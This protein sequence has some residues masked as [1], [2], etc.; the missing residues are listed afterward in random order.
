MS[1]TQPV[2]PIRYQE[3]I[4]KDFSNLSCNFSKSHHSMIAELRELINSIHD[5]DF[6]NI[7]LE[8]G[9]FLC[10]LLIELN[11]SSYQISDLECHLNISEQEIISAMFD[12]SETIQKENRPH[13]SIY[14]NPNLTAPLEVAISY[15]YD[16]L[17]KY[18]LDE[19]EII[20]LN[21]KKLC[22]RENS[23]YGR[24]FGGSFYEN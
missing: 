8:L 3:I 4:Q 14:R 10:Y 18:H 9:D 1:K 21:H 5:D 15:F 7:K 17:N 20:A 16:V 23:G 13:C 19:Q 6:D 11:L 2:D 22:E 12:I 24:S